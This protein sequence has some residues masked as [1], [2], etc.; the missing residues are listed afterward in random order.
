MTF[1]TTV[2]TLGPTELAVHDGLELRPVSQVPI[3][4][5]IS[6]LSKQFDLFSY[7]A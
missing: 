1:V 6:S 7:L 3:I 2:E 5:L 4:P